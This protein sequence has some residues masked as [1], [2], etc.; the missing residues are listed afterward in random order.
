[1]KRN[2]KKRKEKSRKERGETQIESIGSPQKVRFKRLKGK[3]RKREQATE[4]L[5]K[6][7]ERRTETRGL[8]RTEPSVHSRCK[9]ICPHKM[10]AYVY[11]HHLLSTAL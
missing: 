2:E 7:E 3:V 8:G 6:R 11:Y 5:G 1:M 4:S 9:L 10:L